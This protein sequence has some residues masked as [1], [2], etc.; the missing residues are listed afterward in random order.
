M[1]YAK[2]RKRPAPDCHVP[3][4]THYGDCIVPKA[5]FTAAASPVAI[6]A[7]ANI[8]IVDGKP[9]DVNVHD[10]PLATIIDQMVEAEAQSYGSHIRIAAKLNDLLPFAWYDIG[11]TETGEDAS[12][13]KPYWKAVY[14]GFK[15]AGHS[16]PSVPGKRIR[17]YGRNLRA[18]LAPNGKTMADGSPL[19]AGEGEATGEGANPA[20]R[21]PM[22]RNIE[23]LSAL[24]KF[25]A[26]QDKLPEK[27][28]AAQ[29]HIASALTALGL[30]VR[31][32]K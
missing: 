18:G 9:I 20:K 22:L 26:K 6:A 29:A 19:P 32:L 11:A 31:T 27:V 30:D 4:G 3:D 28:V 7:N 21:S 8:V 2:H 1:V 16:N 15:R 17:D 10:V 23:E 25:N 12:T 5:K 13:F 24:W 14:D